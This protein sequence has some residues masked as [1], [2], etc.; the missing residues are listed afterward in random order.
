MCAFDFGYSEL[1]DR[2][3][4]TQDESKLRQTASQMWLLT[5]IFPI[6]VGDL[7]PR[8][9]RKWNCFLKLARIC[10]R[11]VAPVLSADSAAYLEILIEEHHQQF[12]DLYPDE[13]ITPKMHFMVH[14]PQQILKYGP[15][16]HTWTMRHEAKLRVIKRAAR[17]SNFKNVC[18]TVAKRHQHLLCF[19]I[20]SH[21]LLGKAI[22]SGPCKKVSF[23][24]QPECLQL[25]LT[26]QFQLTNESIIFTSS[27]V[28][29]NGITFNICFVI[30]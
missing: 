13:S 11:C 20:H 18:Q 28:A 12:R 9:N 21:L 15:L 24:A 2:P 26:R 1:G 16:V 23:T 7:I 3:A 30:L 14:F 22:K 19:Y 8:D 6:L 17:L 25:M 4:P 27:Y 29:Y 10:E 5:T